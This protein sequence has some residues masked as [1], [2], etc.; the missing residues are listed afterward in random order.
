MNVKKWSDEK[1]TTTQ[2]ELDAWC[3]KHSKSSWAGRF[4]LFLALIGAFAISTGVVFLFFDGITAMSFILIAL[5]LVTSV[6][7]YKTEQQRKINTGFLAEVKTEI[8]RRAKKEA[9][10]KPESAKSKT[11]QAEAAVAAKTVA[12]PAAQAAAVEKPETAEKAEATPTAV[13]EEAAERK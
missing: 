5:G 6:T 1:L 8:A 2:T 3:F 11:A 13:S 12:P 10:A 9:P 7:W 4:E